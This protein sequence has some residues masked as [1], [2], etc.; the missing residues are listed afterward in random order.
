MAG[1][2]SKTV[3]F[4]II[5]SLILFIASSCNS[6][7]KIEK[8]LRS[9][10]KEDMIEGAYRAGETGNKK[11]VP[12]LLRNAYDPRGTTNLKFKGISVYQSKMG[13]LKKILK[14]E[15]PVTITRKPDSLVIKFY[16]ETY[17]NRF[18]R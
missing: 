4:S 1:F 15:P 10:D 7:E 18:L 11:F 9:N 5:F 16:T 8:L 12:L 17:I 14:Q 13:A 3:C 6:D 2:K